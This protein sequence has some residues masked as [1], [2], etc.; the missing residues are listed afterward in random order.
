M[1]NIDFDRYKNNILNFKS[2][3]EIDFEAVGNRLTEDTVA[4]VRD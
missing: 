2:I 4:A 1:A 3:E